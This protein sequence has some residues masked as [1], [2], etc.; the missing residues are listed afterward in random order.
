MDWVERGPC[1]AQPERMYAEGAAQ[2]EAKAVCAGCPVRIDC[3]AHALDHREEYGVW[4]AMTGRERRA[5]LRRR[6]GVRSW[7]RL[8]AQARTHQDTLLIDIVER[9]VA[10]RSP[11]TRADRD[12]RRAE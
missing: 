7:A 5:L 3:L 11:G 9:R 4:G 8:F 6:P 1:R 10:D 12:G 2:N